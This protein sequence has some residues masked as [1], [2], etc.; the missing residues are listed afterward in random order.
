MVETNLLSELSPEFLQG[1]ETTTPTMPPDADKEISRVPIIWRKLDPAI[2]SAVIFL[3]PCFVLA[4]ISPYM[5]RQ[6]ARQMTHVGTVSGLVYAA[7]TVG[8]IGGVLV[9]AYILIDHFST[10]TIFY[11]TGVLTLVLAGLCC[12]IDWLWPE[13]LQEQ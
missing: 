4:M 12:L 10:T 8:S 9:S 2:G 1:S 5:I 13:D 11:L 3:L 6:A 7:S